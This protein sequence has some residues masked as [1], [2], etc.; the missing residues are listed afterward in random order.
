MAMFIADL[1][2]E[3]GLAYAKVG[4]LGASAVAAIVGMLILTRVLPNNQER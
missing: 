3:E 1:A 4:I 2:L